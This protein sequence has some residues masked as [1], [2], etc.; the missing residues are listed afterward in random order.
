MV[1]LIA[2]VSPLRACR[3]DVSAVVYRVKISAQLGRQSLDN[4]RFVKAH[5]LRERRDDYV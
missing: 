3:P 1:G 2:I 4:Q 5:G